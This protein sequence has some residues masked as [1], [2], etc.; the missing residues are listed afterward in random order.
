[1]TV[2]G[3]ENGGDRAGWHTILLAHGDELVAGQPTD[4][5]DAADPADAVNGFLI[6]G[7][8]SDGAVHLSA[9]AVVFDDAKG[10]AGGVNP[11][12]IRCIA[13]DRGHHPMV[14]FRGDVEGGERLIGPAEQS[15]VRVTKPE[16]AASVRGCRVHTCELS[17]RNLDR[18]E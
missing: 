16:A 7:A 3:P 6:E 9:R 8:R 2:V 10:P 5:V 13:A 15:V 1:M 14:Q 18:L 12:A 4:A 17:K 11:D